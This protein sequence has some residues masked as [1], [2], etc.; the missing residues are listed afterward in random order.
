MRA[1]FCFRIPY[2]ILAWES[3]S[4]TPSPLP[5]TRTL[6]RFVGQGSNGSHE[7]LVR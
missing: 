3:F 7:D 6:F 5:W 4:V 2:L 1:T